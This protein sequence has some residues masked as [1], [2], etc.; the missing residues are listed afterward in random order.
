MRWCQTYLTPSHNRNSLQFSRHRLL[1]I[2]TFYN[3]K[4][5]QITEAYEYLDRGKCSENKDLM[6]TIWV[7]LIQGSL[8]EMYEKS[9]E[10]KVTVVRKP[11]QK[12]IASQIIKKGSL[13]LVPLSR[14]IA[15]SVCKNGKA[16]PSIP[17]EAPVV[18]ELFNDKHGNPYTAFIKKDVTYPEKQA[19]ASS[20]ARAERDTF[21][22]A[23]WACE[24]SYERAKVNCERQTK[25]MKTKI[26][27][28]ERAIQVPVIV[29]TIEIAKGAA[30]IVDKISSVVERADDVIEPA[31]KKPRVGANA[32][33]KGRGKG[34]KGKGN[35]KRT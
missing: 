7:G 6:E 5:C 14:S 12:V 30:I 10:D 22:P 13:L 17:Q 21:I 32:P 11:E 27:K 34:T 28:L 33:Q 16:T 25:E 18:G 29:N 19:H 2:K 20:F 24:E 31:Q 4:K 1:Q 35:A 15:F 3:L 23:F 26:G 8:V 9:S